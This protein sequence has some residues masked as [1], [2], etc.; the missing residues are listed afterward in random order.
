MNLEET[1]QDGDVE[2]VRNILSSLYNITD[3]PL[4]IAMENQHDV[5]VYLLFL[6]LFN[7]NRR[8]E[9]PCFSG[10]QLEISKYWN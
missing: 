2:E 4:I 1:C 9:K 5:I 6:T 8:K 7:Y 3:S 10:Q